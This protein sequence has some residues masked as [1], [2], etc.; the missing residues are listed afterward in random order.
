MP[1]FSVLTVMPA[2]LVVAVAFFVKYYPWEEHTDLRK[3]V[4]WNATWGTSEGRKE[5]FRVAVDS[6]DLDGEQN[7]ELK[8]EMMN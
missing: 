7:H 5:S 4:D 6:A 8:F 2:L 1:R 3:M